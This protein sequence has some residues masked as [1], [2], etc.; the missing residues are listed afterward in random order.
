MGVFLRFGFVMKGC[1]RLFKKTTEYFSGMVRFSAQGGNSARFLNACAQKGIAVQEVCATAVGF[2]AKVPL[3][4][5]TRLHH[6]ARKCRCRLRVTEKYGAWFAL[7]AYRARWGII[8]GFVVCG[9]LLALFQGLIWNIT[10]YDFTSQE[11]AHLRS[12]LYEK[13]IYEGSFADLQKLKK[14]Q[15]ELF[16]AND[17]YGWVSLN[18]VHGRIV[19]EKNDVQKETQTL[20][21]TDITNIV[22]R[23]DGIVQFADITGGFLT[24]TK[25]QAVAQG[26]VLVSG[27]R[28][29]VTQMPYYVHAEAKVY[30]EIERIYEV[31]QPFQV[32]CNLPTGKVRTF[33]SLNLPWG[34]LS[35]MPKSAPQENQRV[36]YYPLTV[37]GLHLPATVKELETREHETVN[38]AYTPELAE[39]IACLKALE[40]LKTEFP[41]CEINSLHKTSQQQADGILFHVKVHATADIAEKVPFEAVQTEKRENNS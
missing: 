10:F 3:R 23:C 2:T 11:V 6:I 26:E 12:Q 1:S 35:L 25:G 40:M 37:L 36:A 15:R 31:F 7:R 22:A 38:V 30:A 17:G 29:G 39:Q 13:G 32:K 19:V 4:D 34:T 27:V 41:L 8:A 33:Y 5:Y 28:V 14:V 9:L 21:E 16:V 24:V 18:A 20:P